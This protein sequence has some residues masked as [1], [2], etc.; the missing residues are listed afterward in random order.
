M[1]HGLAVGSFGAGLLRGLAVGSGLLQGC[2]EGDADD[3]APQ[4]EPACEGPLFRPDPSFHHAGC[5]WPFALGGGPFGPPNN[6]PNPF[7]GPLEGPFKAWST[8]VPR[9]PPFALQSTQ[10]TSI[11][12]HVVLAGH[13][14][15]GEFRFFSPPTAHAC[16]F[17]AAASSRVNR[18]P[19]SGLA[20]EK[21]ESSATAKMSV[22]IMMNERGVRV[23]GIEKNR[24]V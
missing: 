4:P 24:K 22:D 7:C 1:L 15:R 14:E 13:G 9:Q 19:A 6:P 10:A 12:T 23:I 18:F 3:G 5:C 16:G 11:L 21:T 2:A 8:H 17:G 20:A